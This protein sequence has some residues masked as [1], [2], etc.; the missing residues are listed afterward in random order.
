[1]CSTSKPFKKYILKK[2]W[3]IP[4]DAVSKHLN[5]NAFEARL[6]KDIISTTYDIYSFACE[7]V[8][9]TVG[10]SSALFANRMIIEYSPLQPNNWC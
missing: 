3:K 4:S 2:Q 1:M 7:T 9:E 8:A 6:R 10:L 5:T